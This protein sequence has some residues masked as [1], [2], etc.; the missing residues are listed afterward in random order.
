MEHKMIATAKAVLAL[1][2]I[3]NRQMKREKITAAP[4]IFESLLC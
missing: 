1:C 2:F 3:R 4:P